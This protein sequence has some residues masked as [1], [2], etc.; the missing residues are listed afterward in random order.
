MTTLL[1]LVV[2]GVLIGAFS[3]FTNAGFGDRRPARAP[4]DRPSSRDIEALLAP[5]ATPAT[6]IA[7][8]RDGHALKIAGRIEAVLQPFGEVA[9]ESGWSARITP[10][11]AGG[12]RARLLVGDSSGRAVVE[13]PYGRVE[14]FTRTAVG[15]E[16]VGS[17]PALIIGQP[18]GVF[19]IGKLR[20]P[21]YRDNA[22]ELI[23]RAAY[24]SAEPPPSK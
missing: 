3:Y 22:A 17:V 6:D 23:V 8:A 9:S 24:V 4:G 1:V 16:P 13:I 10:S 18:I 12:T 7:A 20:A 11:D 14:A 21:G 5:L 2:V 15:W 19:G